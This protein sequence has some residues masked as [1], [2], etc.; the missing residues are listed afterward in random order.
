MRLLIAPKCMLRSIQNFLTEHQK[1]KN[2]KNVCLFF[3]TLPPP[4]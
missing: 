1:R 2:W 4:L 3:L